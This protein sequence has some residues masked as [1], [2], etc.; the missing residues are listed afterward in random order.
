LSV[1]ELEARGLAARDGEAVQCT[2]DG[3]LM[4]ALALDGRSDAAEAELA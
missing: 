3:L 1:A 2:A 4:L